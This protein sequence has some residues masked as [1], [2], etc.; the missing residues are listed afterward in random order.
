MF[1]DW[2]DIEFHPQFCLVK[3]HQWGKLFFAGNLNK[4][5]SKVTIHPHLLNH[6]YILESTPL[7]MFG[8]NI[9]NIH[10]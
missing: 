9:S 3:D 6:L 7:S 10:L 1:H 5:S 4:A 2:P 8:I